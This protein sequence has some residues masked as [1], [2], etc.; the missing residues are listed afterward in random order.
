MQDMTGANHCDRQACRVPPRCGGAQ[1]Q[2]SQKPHAFAAS[3]C[4]VV[5]SSATPELLQKL[6]CCCLQQTLSVIKVHAHDLLESILANPNI[7]DS[8]LMGLPEEHKS[9]LRKRV[10]AAD[11]VS[12]G[13]SVESAAGCYDA[14]CGCNMVQD[15]FV[16]LS[17]TKANL[18]EFASCQLLLRLSMAASGCIRLQCSSCISVSQE[19][20]A[21]HWSNGCCGHCTGG[22]PSLN[23]SKAAAIP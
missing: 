1:L 10:Q 18:L 16:A 21:V 11:L 5:P 20:R 14:S 2:C 17:L 19:W 7:T 23:P 3:W 15:L 6:S 12:E 8:D 22:Y 4:L 13:F 9:V